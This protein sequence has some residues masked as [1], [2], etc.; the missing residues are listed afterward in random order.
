MPPRS[1]HG[2]AFSNEE[3]G[4]PYLI[5]VYPQLPWSLLSSTQLNEEV[6]HRILRRGC[7]AVGP[8]G[9]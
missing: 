6:F 2:N 1:T 7:K 4:D 9:T 5:F 3:S 8:R